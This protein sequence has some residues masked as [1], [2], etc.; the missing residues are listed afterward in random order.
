MG[1]KGNNCWYFKKEINGQKYCNW[2]AVLYSREILLPD[3][4][5]DLKT[6]VDTYIITFK[7][8][9]THTYPILLYCLRSNFHKYSKIQA[10]FY[11][12]NWLTFWFVLIVDFKDHFDYFLIFFDQCTINWIIKAIQSEPILVLEWSLNNFEQFSLN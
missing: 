8:K 2:F 1:L 12:M 9:N 3:N 4:I 7:W 5:E 6:A 10:S 11:H